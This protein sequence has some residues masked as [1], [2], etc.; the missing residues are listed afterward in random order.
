MVG[1][2]VYFF[3]SK[4]ALMRVLISGVVRP[5][6]M[7]STMLS[8][9]ERWQVSSHWTM[10]SLAL[11]MVPALPHGIPF[12]ISSS[13][14]SRS[15]LSTAQVIKLIRAASLPSMRR[16]VSS[17]SMTALCGTT[18]SKAIIVGDGTIP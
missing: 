7:L 16:P 18:R 9:A 13:P 15:A 4:N 12:R 6:L 14:D 5:M 11:A 17:S 3:R 2:N 8:M 10:N 1:R